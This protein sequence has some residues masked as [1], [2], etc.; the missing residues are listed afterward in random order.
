MGAAVALGTLVLLLPAIAC[1]RPFIFWDTPTFY[2]WGHDILAA[3]R[4]PW[5]P[6]DHFPAHR[7]LWAADNMLAAWDR[8]TSRQFQLV[9]TS[10]GA[11]SKFYAVPLYALGSTLTL[12]APAI[13]QA[14]LVAWML[15]VAANAVMPG[16]HL[17]GFAGLV[18]AL[19]VATTA[20]FYAAFLMPDVFAPLGLLAA[21]LLVC[22]P[23]RLTPA[24]R[25]GCAVLVAVAALVHISN[26]VVIVALIAVAASAS[27]FMRPPVSVRRGAFV[28]VVALVG[29]AALAAASDV[30]MRAIFGLPVETAPFLEGRVLAD[31]PGQAFLRETCAQHPYEAC[32]YK[33]LQV[34]FPDDV[35]WPDVSWHHLPLITD[36]AARHRYLDEQGAVV[37][38]TLLHHPFAQLRASLRNAVEQLA[39]FRIADSMGGS[40]SGLLNAN[41]D[42]A[43][44]VRLTVPNL[45]PCLASPA[46]AACDFRQPMRILEKLQFVVVAIAL[47]GL[48]LRLL[49]WHAWRTNPAGGAANEERQRLTL[50]VLALVGAVIA[51]GVFCGAT[52]GAFERYQARVIWLLPMLAVMV[53]MHE[54]GVRAH[55][56]ATAK[57]MEAD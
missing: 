46:A 31:G 56:A 5:P 11:R 9:L 30:G 12:W 15:W 28:V 7:G 50:F 53:E 39:D 27:R 45:G 21:A 3:I 26:A 38:G 29:A 35:I 25:A 55:S 19:T 2:S 22:F 52:S 33:D 20:P 41:T 54:A 10:I 44:R 57:R 32:R 14:A 16:L 49:C 1:G 34:L 36:P 24:Q 4:Q 13:V 42:R 51:N 37:L 48:V 47:A 40:L 23:A 18:V 6:L 17:A 43:L 8:I